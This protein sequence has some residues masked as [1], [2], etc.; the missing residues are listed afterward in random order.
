MTNL[1]NLLQILLFLRGKQNRKNE[2]YYVFNNNELEKRLK[3]ELSDIYDKYIIGIAQIKND[4]CLMSLEFEY[5]TPTFANK[6]ICY[7]KL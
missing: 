3:F 5:I 4:F 2:Y 7:L 6:I 1:T